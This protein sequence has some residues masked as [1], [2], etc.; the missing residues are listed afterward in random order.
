MSREDISE[1]IELDVFVFV[2][3]QFSKQRQGTL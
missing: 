1:P 2:V 3:E